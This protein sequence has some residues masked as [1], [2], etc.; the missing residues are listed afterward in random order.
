MAANCS[1]PVFIAGLH[2]TL[3]S[4][5]FAATLHL[6]FTSCSWFSP[7]VQHLHYSVLPLVSSA[8]L[9]LLFMISISSQLF[10]ILSLFCCVLASFLVTVLFL[11]CMT[12]APLKGDFCSQFC[13]HPSIKSHTRPDRNFS[14]TQ[15]GTGLNFWCLSTLLSEKEGEVKGVRAGPQLKI[16]LSPAEAL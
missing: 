15:K 9:Y 3:L 2:P 8:A 14:C 10:C 7:A 1:V 12:W 11:L 4:S 5:T 13:V 16:A 6:S